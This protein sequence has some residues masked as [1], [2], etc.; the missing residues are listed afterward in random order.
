M[1]ITVIISIMHESNLTEVHNAYLVFHHHVLDTL[2][3][4]AKKLCLVSKV[5]HRGV[6]EKYKHS[7]IHHQEVCC[8][9]IY[10]MSINSIALLGA[11]RNIP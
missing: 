10:A 9:S 6:P 7:V 2:R 4:L 11:Y 3:L 5:L 8:I 1:P